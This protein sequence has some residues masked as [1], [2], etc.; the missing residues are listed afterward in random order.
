[1]AKIVWYQNGTRM[2][3]EFEWTT[4]ETCGGSAYHGEKEKKGEK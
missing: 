1:M 4:F 3:L 2:E